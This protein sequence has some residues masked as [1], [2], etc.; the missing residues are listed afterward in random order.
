MKLVAKRF[1]ETETEPTKQDLMREA[2]RELLF[3]E[4]LLPRQTEVG[5]QSP[6][7]LN[8]RVQ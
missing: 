3:R 5:A 2:L 1:D 8:K 7:S 4:G 6:L